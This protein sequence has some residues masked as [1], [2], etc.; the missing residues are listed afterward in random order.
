VA[1][2]A[3]AKLEKT[4]TQGVY[5]RHK[6]GCARAGKC[7]CAYVV[8]YDNRATTYRTM[9]EA[10]EG[11]AQRRRGAALSRAHAQALH[12]DV[13]KGECPDC[14]RE[15]A[16]LD[17]LAPLLREYA[18]DWIERYYGTGKRGFRE[19][20]RAEYRKLLH[21]YTLTYFPAT[22]RLRDVGPKQIAE[23]IAWLLKQP[24]GRGGQ[25]TDKSV[26]NALAPLRA[27]LGC[28]VREQVD[29]MFRA[30]PLVGAAIPH[31]ARIEEDEELPRPFPGDTRARRQHDP[32]RSPA[33]VRAARRDRA[34]PIPVAR[35][36]GPPHHR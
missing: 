28:A 21:K 15:R 25:L 2:M 13:P 12:R 26:R 17:D 31:R 7:S 20:T 19:E 29:P 3:G 23:L 14:R 24:N 18:T 11:K 1:L 4:T 32:S 35:A 22:A 6:A 16:E 30:N 36:R 33:D 8:V 34:A 5:R 9:A 27:C 10:I